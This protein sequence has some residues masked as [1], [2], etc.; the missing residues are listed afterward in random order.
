[1]DVVV[2]MAPAHSVGPIR[3]VMA[4]VIV[5]IYIYMIYIYD[6]WICDAHSGRKEIAASSW[7]I[8]SIYSGTICFD[9]ERYS[10]SCQI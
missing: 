4:S 5:G 7:P 10:R 8:Y 2:I 1:M 3:C 6:G 9:L